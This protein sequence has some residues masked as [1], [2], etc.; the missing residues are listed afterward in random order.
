MCFVNYCSNVRGYYYNLVTINT[1]PSTQKKIHL[2]PLLLLKKS[3][4]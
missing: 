2:I 3:L 1:P 4:I